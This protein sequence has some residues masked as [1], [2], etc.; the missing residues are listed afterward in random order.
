MSPRFSTTSELAPLLLMST[1]RAASMRGLG[2]STPN[3]VGDL[4]LSTDRQNLPA[5]SQQ[6]QRR[7]LTNKALLR[8]QGSKNAC[9]ALKPRVKLI[10]P[11]VNRWQKAE[12]KPNINAKR[13]CRSCRPTELR[14]ERYTGRRPG[15]THDG[16][17]IALPLECSLV[18]RS[19]RACLPQRRGHSRLFAID[20]CDREIIAWSAT[21][22]GISGEIVRDLSVACVERRFGISKI[23]Q[24]IGWLSDNG[25]A[26]IAKDTLDTATALGLNLCFA[27]VRSP[28]SNAIAVSATK[29][30]VRQTGCTHQ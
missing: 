26:Y 29:L 17:V 3:R 13:C 6:L 18:L 2:G 23:P 20:A 10:T 22:A 14:L 7:I 12:G 5:V 25:S 8:C 1:M 9:T 16:I 24:A 28:E 21:T 27:P 15:R 4:P 30:P 19:L 11:L